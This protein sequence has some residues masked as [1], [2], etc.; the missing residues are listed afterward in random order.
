MGNI[1]L[2]YCVSRETSNHDHDQHKAKRSLTNT[3]ARENMI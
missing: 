3:E 2:F 1:G